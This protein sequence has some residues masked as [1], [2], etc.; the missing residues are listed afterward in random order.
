MG[1]FLQFTYEVPGD[2][3]Q[4]IDYE[5]SHLLSKQSQDSLMLS[6]PHRYMALCAKQVALAVFN[7]TK[8][9]ILR[10][11]LTFVRD[12]FGRIFLQTIENMWVREPVEGWDANFTIKTFIE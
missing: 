4:Q 3:D 7:Q 8:R 12:E 11:T 9:E 1:S 5:W 10:M 2:F 6:D